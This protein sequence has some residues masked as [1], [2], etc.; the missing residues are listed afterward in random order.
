MRRLLLSAPLGSA[1]LGIAV[2]GIAGFTAS[3][4]RR[5]PMSLL[6]VLAIAVLGGCSG[7]A[8]NA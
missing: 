1:V 6:A 3:G 4:R 2:L 7:A 8:A 5:R